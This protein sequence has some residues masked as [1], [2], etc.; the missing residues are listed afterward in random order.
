MVDRLL[1]WQPLMMRMQ[2]VRLKTQPWLLWTCLKCQNIQ[3]SQH[4]LASSITSSET[5]ARR[6]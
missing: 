1:T 2:V 5:G 6:I 4:Q 3:S